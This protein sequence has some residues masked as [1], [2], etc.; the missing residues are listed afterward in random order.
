MGSSI[1]CNAF[2]WA[3]KTSFGAN[4]DMKR[5]NAGIWWQG[6]RGMTWQKFERKVET[7]LQYED[8]PDFLVIHCGG[9]NVGIGPKSIVLRKRMEKTLKFY[10]T[11]LPNTR[12][13]WSQ[14]LPRSSWRSS[15]HGTKLNKVRRRLNSKL[16]SLAIELGGAYIRYPELSRFDSNFFENDKVHLNAMGNNIFLYRIQQ[17]LQTFLSTNRSVSPNSGEFGPWLHLL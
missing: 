13:V 10:K 2:L 6:Q 16:A 8:P 15:I 12:I 17:A 14:I 1:V 4:L 5:H 11:K 3:K 7:L 9:N